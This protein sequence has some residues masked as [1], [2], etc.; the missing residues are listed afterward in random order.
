MELDRICQNCSSFFQDSRDTDL[1]IC[2]NDEVF[3][4]FLDEIMENADFSNCYD[5]Y[6]KKR[7][8]GGKEA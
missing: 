7:F 2:L 8:D 3:E 6:L 4:P 5:I 1:G